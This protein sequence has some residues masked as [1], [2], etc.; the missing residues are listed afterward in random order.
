MTSRRPAHG[1]WL[2]LVL[3]VGGLIGSLAGFRM[4][5]DRPPLAH[6]SIEPPPGTRLRYS[7]DVAGPPVVSPDGSAI[8][9]AA[10]SDGG[11][12]RL[13]IRYLN[14]IRA[15]EIRGTD[16]AIFPFWSPDRKMI[17]FFTKDKLRR[18]DLATN[19]IMTVCNVTEARGGAWTNDGRILLSPVFRSPVYIVDEAGGEPQPITTL[20]L[21][22]FTTHRWPCML[23]DGRRF[24]FFA[25]HCS[26]TLRSTHQGIYMG[27]LDGT[28]PRQLLRAEFGA[29]FAADHLFFVRDG[30]LLASRVDFD[31][32]RLVGKRHVVA[33][34]I[35][36]DPST[37]HHQFS[38]SPNGVL[39][40][41]PAT[42]AGESAKGRK[43]LLSFELE[44]D[45]VGPYDETGRIETNYADGV[46]HTWV[47]LSPNGRS[48]AL[49]VP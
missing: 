30:V 39:V 49:A 46:P 34:D 5:Q 23:P 29:V 25:S 26:S 3:I 20:D 48:L 45:T 4:A 7:G 36:A 44:G 14:E 41:K 18:V 15:K 22:K 31:A 9:F 47:A 6:L 33:R 16:G 38:V 24:L 11:P 21:E 17:G 8:A 19:T 42:D 13:W 10:V 2:L 12:Q 1:A 37:W 27:Y 32:T 40:F 43:S 35:A 28:E